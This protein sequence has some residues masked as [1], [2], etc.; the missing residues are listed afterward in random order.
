MAITKEDIF[1][2]AND[3][4]AAGQN[5]TLATVRKALGGGS[6]TTISEAM[7]EWRNQKAAKETVI[8]EK[9][10]QTLQDHIDHLGGELWTMALTLANGRL[11]AERQALETARTQLESERSEAAEMADQISQELES[12]KQRFSD[13]EKTHK[14][15]QATN[16]K[17]QAQLAHATERAT[18]AEVRAV[19]ISK[20][21]D[22]LNTELARVNTQNTELLHALTG[23]Q[24]AERKQA[25]ERK[26][27][28]AQQ[29]TTKPE[30]GKKITKN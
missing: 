21:A 7:N 22:D 8:R 10:P 16:E 15:T 13:L 20:R 24:E 19:E 11:E 6:F 12:T 5:P 30:P 23:K 27:E 29:E 9:P 1:R 2:I 3:I 14:A 17:L 28:S 4:D 18:T 25:T 26:Q